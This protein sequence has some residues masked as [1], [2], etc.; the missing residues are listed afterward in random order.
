MLSGYGSIT[1]ML[2]GPQ[3]YC[4][5]D[6]SQNYSGG[7]NVRPQ[8]SR[9]PKKTFPTF[10]VFFITHPCMAS[11]PGHR[12]FFHNLEWN[13]TPKH[14]CFWNSCGMSSYPKNYKKRKKNIMNDKSL[15]GRQ[16]APGL[17]LHCIPNY[18]PYQA[19]SV[20]YLLISWTHDVS[21]VSTRKYAWLPV[22][23][24]H[25]IVTSL[26]DQTR[27]PSPMPFSSLGSSSSRKMLKCIRTLINH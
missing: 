21:E 13:L 15:P 17:H 27:P 24:T 8:T 16:R 7:K 19:T 2:R 6:V 22:M 5:S 12:I 20:N 18:S 4:I 11:Y 10:S 25:T 26:R 9:F 1:I 14:R 3:Q 23:P